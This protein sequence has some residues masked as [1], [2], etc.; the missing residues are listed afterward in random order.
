MRYLCG[1]SVKEEQESKDG[2]PLFMVPN[3]PTRLQVSTGAQG[4]SEIELE[5][6]YSPLL[7]S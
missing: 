6:F 3:T 5:C 1:W 4:Y 2:D 7:F